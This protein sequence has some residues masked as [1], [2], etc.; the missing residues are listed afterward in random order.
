MILLYTSVWSVMSIIGI[1]KTN[2]IEMVCGRRLLPQSEMPLNSSSSIRRITGRVPV[3]TN[4]FL[5]Q[6]LIDRNQTTA[7]NLSHLCEIVS[8]DYNQRK[9]NSYK[10]ITHSI[11]LLRLKAGKLKTNIIKGKRG[12]HLSGVKLSDDQKAAMKA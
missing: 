8:T 11:V 1:A 5:L 4:D 7:T 6:E 10:P 9:A 3:E 12:S 2:M